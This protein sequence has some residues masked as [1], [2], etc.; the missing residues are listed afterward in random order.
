ML[1]FSASVISSSGTLIYCPYLI[2]E[3]LH[4]TSLMAITLQRKL[5]LSICKDF[6]AGHVTLIH[7]KVIVILTKV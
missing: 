7:I 6:L 5:I 3:I 1:V 2:L 4:N